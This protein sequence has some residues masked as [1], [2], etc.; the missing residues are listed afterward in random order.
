MTEFTDVRQA[1]EC[2]GLTEKARPGLECK[3]IIEHLTVKLRKSDVESEVFEWL[4]TMIA[5]DIWRQVE[6]R[7]KKPYA[8]EKVD[9]PPPAKIEASKPPVSDNPF[10]W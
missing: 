6:A 5:N 8:Q 10:D 7:H 2:Y 9:E 3:S 1:I 4:L